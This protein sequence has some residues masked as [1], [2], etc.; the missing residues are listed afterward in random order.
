MYSEGQLIDVVEEWRGHEWS[1]IS[2]S[3]VNSDADGALVTHERRG[4]VG[5]YASSRGVPGREALSRSER[6]FRAQETLRFRMVEVA[7]PIDT[8]HFWE[9]GRFARINRGWGD[10]HFLG[11]YVDFQ[12]PPI[13]EAARIVTMDL[14]LDA[15][16]APDGTWTWKDRDDFEEAQLR[17]LVTDH[18]AEQVW[19]EASRLQDHA[20][21]RLGAWA[22]EWDLWTPHA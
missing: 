16:V 13:I 21:R 6:K 1:R 17:G 18:E 3:I 12:R 8:L 19:A 20:A 10:G 9:P 2:H 22:S 7:A 15:L 4:T 14:V 5:H 11:W